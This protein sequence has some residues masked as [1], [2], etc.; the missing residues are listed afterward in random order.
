MV[1]TGSV[2]GDTGPTIILLKGKIKRAIFNDAYLVRHRLK[3]GSTIIMTENAFMTH[4]AWYK[5]TK[6]IIYG[7]NEM[8][9]IRDNPQWAILKFL[10]DF[11]S[12]EYEPRALKM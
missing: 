5:A 9:V 11:G 1:R 8:P 2:A 6:A 12:H 7:Y 10:D 3:P 4:D